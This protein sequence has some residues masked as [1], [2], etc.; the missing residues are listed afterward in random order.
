MEINNFYEARCIQ[1]IKQHFM[2][3]GYPE[4]AFYTQ[5]RFQKY[6]ADF[7]LQPF[8]KEDHFVIF[9]IKQKETLE[10]FGFSFY[11]KIAH[12]LPKNALFVFAYLDKAENLQLLPMTLEVPE[13]QFERL[14]QSDL[15]FNYPTYETALLQRKKHQETQ[16]K[17]TIKKQKDLFTILCY[18]DTIVLVG[19]FI[20]ELFN[21]FRWTTERVI[22][23]IVIVILPLLPLF[24]EIKIGDYSFKREKSKK[25]DE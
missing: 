16:K 5:Q 10:A 6:V 1:K 12:Y 11:H 22:V 13:E 24:A 2:E 21:I 18:I 9:E 19:L 8:N 25:Q 20:L 23:Y 17:K 3:L 4:S 15:G 14:L 7:V